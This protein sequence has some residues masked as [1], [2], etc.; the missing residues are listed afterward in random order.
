MK[1]GDRENLNEW[2]V[3][4]E[5]ERAREAAQLKIV[6][7]LLKLAIGK[8]YKVDITPSFLKLFL[9]TCDISNIFEHIIHADSTYNAE[10]YPHANNTLPNDALM[11][12]LNDH[13]KPTPVNNLPGID[14]VEDVAELLKGMTKRVISESLIVDIDSAWET[15]W[16]RIETETRCCEQLEETSD[17][18]Q[19]A[20]LFLEMGK[21]KEAYN[22]YQKISSEELHNPDNMLDLVE[23]TERFQSK[24]AAMQI[25]RRWFILQ[26]VVHPLTYELIADILLPGTSN[27][28]S[29]RRDFLTSILVQPESIDLNELYE[30]MTLIIPAETQV[31]LDFPEIE[32][33]LQKLGIKYLDLNDFFSEDDSVCF[34]ALLT[35]ICS[36]LNHL[37]TLAFQTDHRLTALLAIERCILCSLVLLCLPPRSEDIH[38][39]VG[40]GSYNVCHEWI[41]ENIQEAVVMLDMIDIKSSFELSTYR[42]ICQMFDA[43]QNILKLIT[44]KSLSDARHDRY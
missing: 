30:K 1:S 33:R 19:R 43:L 3:I 44:Q 9:Q 11:E 32:I 21:E 25:L 4:D 7:S 14:D 42:R 27:K 20:A 16:Q 10:S 35:N 28:N 8:P 36:Q 40:F 38:H 31:P 6:K 39:V 5:P 23:L 29:I 34:Y 26:I 15:T 41:V 24:S 22:E 12:L 37:A 13:D 2:P 17:A 18:I